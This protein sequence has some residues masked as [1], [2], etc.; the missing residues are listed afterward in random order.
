MLFTAGFVFV[1]YERLVIF[2]SKMLYQ[3]YLEHI[4]SKHHLRRLFILYLLLQVQGDQGGQ[5]GQEVR[6]NH[7]FHL[8]REDPVKQR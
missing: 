2:S 3:H 1:S 4:C 8:G 6:V 5:R 7:L